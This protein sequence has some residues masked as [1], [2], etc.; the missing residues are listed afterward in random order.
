MTFATAARGGFACLS[1]VHHLAGKMEVG[2]TMLKRTISALIASAAIL[3]TGAVPAGAGTTLGYAGFTPGQGTGEVHATPD[4]TGW[5]TAQQDTGTFAGVTKLFDPAAGYPNLPTSWKGDMA[6]FAANNG[7]HPLLPLIA[8]NNV[9]T[10]A[11]FE[12]LMATLPAGQQLGFV[13]QSEAESSS[14]G[15]TGPV[16]LAN[17]AKI[18][19]N[20]N[21]ALTFM[22]ANPAPGNTAAFYVRS[23]FM[24][25]N[26]AYMAYYATHS[27]SKAFIPPPSQV[28]AYGADFYQ[29]VGSGT[30]QHVGLQSDSRYQGYLKGV[31]AVAGPNPPLAFPEYGIGMQIYTAANEQARAALLTK[32]FGYL[33]GGSRPSGTNVTVLINYW[34]QTDASPNFYTFPKIPGETVNQAAPTINEWQTISAAAGS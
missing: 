26:S 2:V 16:F 33:T 23:N 1:P 8:F 6:T 32:D 10:A 27:G 22:A 17:W 34:Y 15:I 13:Y 24:M 20:L 30:T 31:H 5:T 28:D 18:S 3:L 19:A 14:S 12:S 21:T 7:G 9:P 25:V 29:H 4:L 11:N